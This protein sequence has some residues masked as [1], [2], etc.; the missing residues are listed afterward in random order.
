MSV[1]ITVLYLLYSTGN[2]QSDL[3][4]YIHTAQW[5]N[6][7]YGILLYSYR[8]NASV[9]IFTALQEHHTT[10]CHGTDL[11]NNQCCPSPGENSFV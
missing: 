1:C 9:L 8:Q 11:T 10:S 6:P 4:T 3:L 5:M 7:W 2:L